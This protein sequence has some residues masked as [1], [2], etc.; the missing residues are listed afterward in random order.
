MQETKYLPA[1]T[2]RQRGLLALYQVEM[3]Y[4]RATSDW[5]SLLSALSCLAALG[6]LSVG[7][8]LFAL[9][10]V[11]QHPDLANINIPLLFSSSN[12]GVMLVYS[13]IHAFAQAK[14][15]EYDCRTLDPFTPGFKGGLISA[16]WVMC[17]IAL[18]TSLSFAVAY[19]EILV[20]GWR[21]ADAWSS[22]TWCLA[23]IPATCLVFTYT[24]WSYCKDSKDTLPAGYWRGSSGKS[25]IFFLM[26]LNVASSVCN[27]SLSIRTLDSG[28]C[29]GAIAYAVVSFGVCFYCS[30]LFRE[31][32]NDSEDRGVSC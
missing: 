32:V 5:L 3:L 24:Y 30:V 11:P 1:P 7:H 14:E 29:F 19:F 8:Y 27:I 25:M 12:L 31:G 10:P 21:S 9:V 23:G 2:D 20:L 15:A 26:I 22:A 28:I 4:Q 17:V 16:R 13:W 6:F 18:F